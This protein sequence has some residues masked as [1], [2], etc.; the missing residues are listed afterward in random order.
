A[1][2]LTCADSRIPVEMLFDRSPG[3]LFTLRVA[4]N[5]LTPHHEGSI[6]FAVLELSTP[7]CL[8]MGHTR[9]G[10]I[11]AALAAERSGQVPTSPNLSCLIGELRSAVRAPGGG[12]RESIDACWENVRQSV[13]RLRRNP[14]LAPRIAEG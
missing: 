13:L 10:A 6:E 3:E 4:G 9:C 5:V 8:V 12:P 14:I 1:A 2:I 7:L 11:S